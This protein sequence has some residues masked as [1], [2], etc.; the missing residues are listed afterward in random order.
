MQQQSNMKF[1]ILKKM[2]TILTFCNF[3]TRNGTVV[4]SIYGI[5]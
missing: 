1:D 5:L 2:E 4:L 3:A